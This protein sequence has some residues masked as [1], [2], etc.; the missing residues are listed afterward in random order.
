[1]LF[2]FGFFMMIEGPREPPFKQEPGAAMLSNY[3]R[4]AGKLL[5]K[6]KTSAQPGFALLRLRKRDEPAVTHPLAA[7]R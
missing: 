2:I 7:D 5:R 3:L 6:C 4:R 1:M